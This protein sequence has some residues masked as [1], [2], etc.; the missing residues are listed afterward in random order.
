M[1]NSELPAGYIQRS[2]V[3][4]ASV[5]RRSA[6]DRWTPEI[7]KAGHIQIAR[8]FLRN[9]RNLDPPLTL[10]EAMFVIHLMDFKWDNEAPWP[11]YKTLARYMGMTDKQVRRLAKS[12]EDK[13][14]LRREVRTAEAN[15]FHLE[16]LFRRLEEILVFLAPALPALP[17]APPALPAATQAQRSEF[18]TGETWEVEQESK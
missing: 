4:R 16:S 9:Y 1:S 11:R 6:A 10:G 7:A 17:T 15:R 3:P 2:R 8:S 12:L 14:Y 18:V 5:K 13:G